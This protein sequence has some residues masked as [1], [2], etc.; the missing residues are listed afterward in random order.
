MLKS[1]LFDVDIVS[2][3][4]NEIHDVQERMII[5]SAESNVEEE[6][7]LE[8]LRTLTKIKRD[9]K[10]FRENLDAGCVL[11]KEPKNINKVACN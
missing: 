9:L 2:N 4:I 3:Y 10:E 5:E 1:D 8:H 11:W 7:I 6:T